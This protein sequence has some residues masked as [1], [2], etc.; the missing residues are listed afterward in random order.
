MTAK[1]SIVSYFSMLIIFTVSVLDRVHEVAA[2][3]VG[4]DNDLARLAGL[5]NRANDPRAG[6]GIEA[7]HT[8]QVGMALDDGGGIGATL[9]DIGARF[10]IGDHLHLRTAFGQRIA[11]ALAGLNEV[12]GGKERDRADLA[13]LETR[14]SVITALIFAVPVA[15]IVPVGAEVGEALRHRRSPS[16]TTV[17]TFLSMHLSTSDARASSQPPTTITPRRVLGALG[18]DGGDEG[19]EIDRG[20][21]GECGH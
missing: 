20:R 9:L 8:S 11:Q 12:A 16:V 19:A 15:Q 18:I 3:L 1:K 13:R 7:D 4:C 21:T 10:L 6:F 2:G 17:G 14:I 5:G